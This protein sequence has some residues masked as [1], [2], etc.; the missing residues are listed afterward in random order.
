VT[1]LG[2]RKN[3]S[4]EMA[5]IEFVKNDYLKEEENEIQITLEMNDMMTFWDWE[6][7][8]LDQ[9]IDYYEDHLR[10]L[11]AKID[12]EVNVVLMSQAK[13]DIE[14]I[15]APIKKGKGKKSNTKKPKVNENDVRQRVELKYAKQKEVLLEGYARA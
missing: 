9:E 10:R 5:M 15:K 7:R 1:H 12:S 4:A 14:F 13:D 2:R 3:D 11:K 8:L 6:N